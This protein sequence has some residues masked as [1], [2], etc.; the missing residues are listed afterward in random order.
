MKRVFQKNVPSG[1]IQSWA[2]FKLI[3]SL[4]LLFAWLTQGFVPLRV[5]HFDLGAF[6]LAQFGYYCLWARST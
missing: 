2:V 4:F 1:S 6:S 5:M 3:V